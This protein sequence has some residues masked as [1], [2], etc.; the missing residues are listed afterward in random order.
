MAPPASAFRKQKETFVY[1]LLVCQAWDVHPIGSKRFKKHRNSDHAIHASS[2]SF[3]TC[4]RCSI[5]RGRTSA[6]HSPV[7][8]WNLSAPAQSSNCWQQKAVAARGCTQL[9]SCDFPLVLLATN[10]HLL[11]RWL[12]QA[13]GNTDQIMIKS[14]VGEVSA[15]STMS[16]T[17]WRIATRQETTSSS[18]HKV[19]DL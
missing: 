13:T 3:D 12:N 9:F 19:W 2:W 4:L 5:S 1:V 7:Q 15:C 18:G 16:S 14:I 10:G 8:F 17:L 11:R 6:R